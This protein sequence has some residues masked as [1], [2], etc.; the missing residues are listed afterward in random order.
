MPHVQLHEFLPHELLH[1]ARTVARDQRDK[2]VSTQVTPPREGFRQSTVLN[3]DHFVDLHEAF[4][5]HLWSRLPGILKSIGMILPAAS[6]ELQ[7]TA[8]HCGDFFKKHI[9]SGSDD[10]RTRRLSFVCYFQLSGGGAFTGGQLRV[11][12]GVTYQLKRL[13]PL[14]IFSP[15]PTIIQPI[16][17]S[18]VVFRSSQTHEVMPVICGDRWEDGR[19]SLNGWL[20]A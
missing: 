11:Y 6:L 15:F 14:R 19:F 8:H 9:D 1:Q 17:N 12:R 7:M 4:R 2:F 10:T 5:L 16:H 3:A 18:I 20:R 13:G